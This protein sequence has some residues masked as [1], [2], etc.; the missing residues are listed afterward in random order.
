LNTVEFELFAIEFTKVC[1]LL[2]PAFPRHS[3]VG[4]LSKSL[5]DKSKSSRYLKIPVSTDLHIK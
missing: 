2:T 5:V 4:V 1:G 3:A